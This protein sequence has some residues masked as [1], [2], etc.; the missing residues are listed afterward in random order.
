MLNLG[1]DP[2]DAVANQCSSTYLGNRLDQNR[3]QSGAMASVSCLSP[4]RRRWSRHTWLERTGF[5]RIYEAA[6]S[7]QRHSLLR[8]FIDAISIDTAAGLL[9]VIF[10][11]PGPATP[12]PA[13]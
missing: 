10:R 4:N 13:R 7:A 2:L 6:S 9:Q 3:G 5:R 1:R 12:D 11:A 8:P